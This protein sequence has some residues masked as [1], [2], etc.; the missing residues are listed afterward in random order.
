MKKPILI[1]AFS[2]SKSKKT[3]QA[4]GTSFEVTIYENNE[5]EIEEYLTELTPE[6]PNKFRMEFKI[7]RR[8]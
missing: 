2:C 5:K 1:F 6:C 7:E 3:V 8:G 4:K